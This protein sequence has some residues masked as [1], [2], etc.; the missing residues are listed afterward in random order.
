MIENEM[1]A[2]VAVEND[3]DKNDSDTMK[4]KEEDIV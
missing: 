1:D 2:A 4:P 3:D